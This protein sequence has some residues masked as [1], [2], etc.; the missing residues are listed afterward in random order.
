MLPSEA[1]NGNLYVTYNIT[2][3]MLISI[4]GFEMLH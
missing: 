1:V 2:K 4:E 3:T